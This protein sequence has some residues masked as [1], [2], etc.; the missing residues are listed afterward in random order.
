[1]RCIETFTKMGTFTKIR[2]NFLKHLSFSVSYR[3][4]WWIEN[5][6]N[7][8]QG[9]KSKGFDCL[10]S[11]HMFCLW[12]WNTCGTQKFHHQIQNVRASPDGLVVKFQRSHCS[13]SPVHFPVAGPHHPSGSCSAVAAAHIEDPEELPTRIY[14]YPVGLW[15]EQKK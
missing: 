8:S 1:M 10:Y 13:G 5:L 15:G 2:G 12:F 3:T 11:R 7:F 6:R 14:N 9:R 4:S